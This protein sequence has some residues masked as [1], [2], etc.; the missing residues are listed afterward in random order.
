[1]D[2]FVKLAFPN[3]LIC[4]LALFSIRSSASE[5][6]DPTRPP[7]VSVGV[8]TAHEPAPILSAIMGAPSA[9]VAIFNGHLVRVGS[10]VGEFLIEAVLEDGVR[11]RHAGTTQELH[12]AHSINAVKKPSS[13]APRLPVGAP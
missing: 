11:Y 6:R 2:Q 1:M 7:A 13:A 12:L 4:I 10:R 3:L 8:P 5:L 9:R